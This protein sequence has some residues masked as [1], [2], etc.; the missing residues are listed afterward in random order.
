MNIKIYRRD[1]D[2]PLPI[3]KTPRSV[4]MDVYSSEQVVIKTHK[5]TA[6]PTGLTIICPETYYYSLYMRSGLSYKNG[7]MLVNGVGVID[8]DYCGIDDEIKFLVTKLP[9]V[10]VDGSFTLEK[11]TRIGQL[12][13]H[14][15]VFPDI[16]WEEVEEDYIR[17][18]SDRGGFGSTGVK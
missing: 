5:V 7:L 8:E 18:Y 10:G 13:F 9:S 15:N 16:E 12:I 2:V 6:V 3:R 4:G 17:K 1:K 11:G 14:M